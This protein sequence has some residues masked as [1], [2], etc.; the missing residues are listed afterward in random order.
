[1]DDFCLVILSFLYPRMEEL[2][3]HPDMIPRRATSI[4]NNEECDEDVSRGDAQVCAEG[5]ETDGDEA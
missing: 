5:L 3:T 1:M 4:E 2:P